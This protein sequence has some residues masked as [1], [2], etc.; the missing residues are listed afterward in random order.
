MC[1]GDIAST[2]RPVPLRGSEIPTYVFCRDGWFA[3]DQNDCE[4]EHLMEVLK[5]L[6]YVESMPAH[7]E[8][9]L[10]E[11]TKGTVRSISRYGFKAFLQ[12][13]RQ[14]AT[15]AQEL[16]ASSR[17]PA[18]GSL[19]RMSLLWSGAAVG[20]VTQA[21]A[22]GGKTA[23]SALQVSMA[24]RAGLV[25]E[26]RQTVGGSEDDAI[27]AK[28]RSCQLRLG[29]LTA[30]FITVY[31]CLFDT[32]L[33]RDCNA[34]M[35]Q[36]RSHSATHV[37]RV[38]AGASLARSLSD[39]DLI[40]LAEAQLSGSVSHGSLL[41]L[42]TV[43]LAVPALKQSRTF[44][45]RVECRLRVSERYRRLLFKL[46]VSQDLLSSQSQLQPQGS[47]H[48]AQDSLAAELSLPYYLLP[49]RG[50][51][52]RGTA[53]KRYPLR[54]IRGKE[55]TSVF[56]VR[57]VK[58]ISHAVVK[59]PRSLVSG[60]SAAVYQQL[61]QCTSR[62]LLSKAQLSLSQ[63]HEDAR[64]DEVVAVEQPEQMERVKIEDIEEAE[65]GEE[66]GEEAEEDEEDE[67][68]EEAEE[69][70]EEAAEEA[71]EAEEEEEG[72]DG[73]KSEDP[74]RSAPSKCLEERSRP[75][76]RRRASQLEEALGDVDDCEWPLLLVWRG[77]GG[78]GNKPPPGVTM[79]CLQDGLAYQRANRTAAVKVSPGELLLALA[80]AHPRWV[81]DGLLAAS[82]KELLRPSPMLE[83]R[84]QWGLRPHQEEGYRWLMS[85]AASGLGC[86]LA[87]AMG[88]GKTRQA[89]SYLLG[90]RAGLKP[91]DPSDARTPGTVPDLRVPDGKPPVAWERALVLAPAILVR[92]DDSV[93][94]KELREA[95][96]LWR[97]PLRVWQWHGERAC[98]LRS[99]A[100]T[101]QWTGPMLE[102]FDVVVTSYESFL[103]N[104]EQFLRESWTVVILDEAQSIKNHAS[105]TAAAVKRLV[106]AP[107]RLALTG[108]PIENSIDD[109]HSILQ[110]VE[111]DCAG[112]LSDFRQRFPDSDEGRSS[113]RRLLQSVTLRREGGEA[114]KMVAKEEVE[115]LGPKA[116]F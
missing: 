51:I 17:S 95:S 38:P 43:L 44:F 108:T 25:D 42:F 12:S 55:M 114:V 34:I 107:Y 2:L 10:A 105:Q 87:D 57:D 29:V 104:H 47:L 39:Q 40:I 15:V 110:F 93:W 100:H 62:R 78:S 101:S 67:E 66:E 92:G 46:K 106:A 79:S 19:V 5:K 85:R 21:T 30:F 26:K 6:R 64:K 32:W 28:V 33:L 71:E 53:V 63:A 48:G 77:E 115:V 113:L 56:I 31:L 76:K 45:L 41:K 9:R 23:Q 89:I 69:G 36:M 109:I 24:P 72:E 73:T 112:S 49:N 88:L 74:S 98:D 86:V 59:H 37:I 8:Q 3:D 61:V 54:K 11:P 83:V 7:L 96:A 16:R 103:M 60:T 13:Q 102:L 99:V 58:Q 65:E 90:I 68:G 75:S 14:D 50:I 97:E 94:Q 18:L 82:L 111:P 22:S 116:D 80:G 1:K 27:V 81:L 52:S 4:L 20:A 35:F 70:E 84:P 91:R